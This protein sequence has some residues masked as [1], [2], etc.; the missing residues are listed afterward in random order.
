MADFRA[1]AN[2][3]ARRL[4]LERQQKVEG[5]VEVT[6]SKAPIVYKDSASQH[7]PDGTPNNLLK[8]AKL[9][10]IDYMWNGG[11]ARSNTGEFVPPRWIPDEEV[12][13]CRRCRSE[14]DWV[15][16]RHHC[17]HCGGVYCHD[18]SPN[19]SLLPVAFG[20]RDPQRVCIDCEQVLRPH[21][22]SLTN[23]I[24]NHQ[25]ANS[26]DISS[27]CSGRYFNL[28]YAN[29]M[30]AEIRK[31]AYST[32]NLFNLDWV[33]DK[34]IPLQ[35][36]SSAKG[37]A[38]ITVVKVGMV[39]APRI[40]TGLV[41]ARLPDGT[42]SAPSAIST[43]G[44][45]WG[46]LVGADLTDYVIIL[47][48]DEAVEAFSGTGQISVGAGV[49]VAAGPVGRAG[50]ATFNV[51]TEGYAPA[52][53][54][55]HSR[56]LYAG[57][58]LEGSVIMSRPGVN[59]NFYGQQIEPRAILTGLVASPRAAQP[60]YDTLFHAM[61]A[62]P[63]PAYVP[64]Y[65]ASL[66]MAMDAELDAEGKEPALD[67]Q[68]RGGRGSDTPDGTGLTR[69]RVDQTHNV[70]ITKAAATPVKL[71]SHGHAGNSY[72][73]SGGST[74]KSGAQEKDDGVFTIDTGGMFDISVGNVGQ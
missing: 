48:T 39:I 11:R 71:G 24:A 4:H 14:F 44:C 41:I 50:G 47:N 63:A 7:G 69:R 60:L 29:D 67:L 51:G 57:L 28:P 31:A 38:F 45:H 20:Q 49:E 53:T 15:N 37:L 43:F 26:I 66:P 25:C 35:L 64:K 55:S 58:G 1:E 21:Q 5:K 34:A 22:A 6:P 10:E 30:A 54:Y 16:R 59:F 65:S 32:H 40:G 13:T 62:G 36:L 52:L 73:N 74:A 9:A 42:W 8:E 18:C 56:G 3:R 19:R 17:R 68:G 12:E 27:Q 70:K 61:S 46:A 33:R 2:E 72:Y 23:T